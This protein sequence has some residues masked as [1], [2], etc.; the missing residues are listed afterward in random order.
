ME[1]AN[2][3]VELLKSHCRFPHHVNLLPWNPI[4]DA[5]YA[6]PE[7]DS[8]KRFQRVLTEAK[9]EATVRSTR[10]RDAKAAC[11]QLRNERQ[12]KKIE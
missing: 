10:G 12:Q 8:V 7:A 5:A 6:R 2:E 9:V 1:H 11:G 3:L 4:D